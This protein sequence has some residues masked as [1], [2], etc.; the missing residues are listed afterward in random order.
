MPNLALQIKQPEIDVAGWQREGQIAGKGMLDNQLAAYDNREKIGQANAL[1]EYR[2]AAKAGDKNAINKLTG[3]PEIQATIFKAL[4]TMEPDKVEAATTKANAM[5]VA[6]QYVASF[7]P[8]SPERT[9]AWNKAIDDLAKNG[10]IDGAQAKYWKETGPSDVLIQ[11]ALGVKAAVDAY[12]K[13]AKEDALTPGQL[14]DVEKQTQEY[15]KNFF[16]PGSTGAYLTTEQIAQ[17]DAATAKYRDDLVNRIT[18]KKAGAVAAPKP[19]LNRGR[20]ATGIA[21]VGLGADNA[22]AGVASLLPQPKPVAAAPAA[23]APVQPAVPAGPPVRAQPASSLGGDGGATPPQ[24]P[25]LKEWKPGL[26]VPPSHKNAVK[27]AGKS[28]DE[29]RAQIQALPSGT[30]IILPDGTPSYRK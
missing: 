30:P 28:A 10:H 29:V 26:G 16:G 15:A 5:G 11:Q 19:A 20:V 3:Y 24:A 1:N 14:L 9:T 18:P 12:A 2:G 6:A 17:R 4:K 8:G 21:A 27:I 23:A 7:A 25:T 22:S 13:S